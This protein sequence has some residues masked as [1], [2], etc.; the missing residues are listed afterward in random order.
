[1]S[2]RRLACALLALAS[3][4]AAWAEAGTEWPSWGNDPGG[5]RYADLRQISPENV[6][7]LEI[8][9]THRTGD[10]SDGTGFGAKSAFEAT[11][12][13]LEN[14]LYFCTPFNRVIA[15]D[16]ATGTERWS[17]DPKIDRTAR[18]ANQ[19]TC[20]GVAAWRDPA[21]DPPAACS[22]R[23]FT[24]TNDARLFALDARS[25]RLCPDFGVGGVVDLNPGVG[26]QEWRGEYQVT[27]PPAIANGIVAVGSAISDNMR[28]DAPSGVVRAFDARSGSLRWAW[29]AA[30]PGPL[31]AGR[32]A[33][34]GWALGSPNVWAP[35]SVDE[36]RDL[37]FAPTGN[38]APDYYGG[39]R[40]PLERYGSSV[41]ALRAASGQV[42]WHFQTV[43]HDLWDYDVA[44]QPTLSE[45]A[46]D[47]RRIPAVI[48]G[49]KMGMLFVLD[50]ET[51]EPLFP[52]EERPVP[53]SRV[54]GEVS[55]PTQP[56]PVKPP[57]LAAHALP[58]D[59]AWG[60]TPLDRAWCRQ[61]LAKLRYEGIYTPPDL[62]EGTLMYPG[63][64]G[65]INWGGVAVDPVRRIL[66]VNVNQVPF[67][68]SLMPAAQLDS[69][70][71]TGHG[72]H[73]AEYAPQR[74]TPY[75]MRRTLFVSPL[76]APCT[77]PPWGKLVAVDLDR[78]EIRWDVAFGTLRDIAPVPIPIELGT[79]NA[80]GPLVTSAGLVFIG[81]ALDDYLR[82]FDT[83]TG[84]ELWRGRLPAGGQ[85]TPMSYL[86]GGRQFVVI[87]A[88]GSGSA[89]TRPGDFVVAFALP[90]P[91]E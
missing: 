13:L 60:F 70:K 31:P 86:S 14:T 56:F 16:P 3:A 36:A 69:A 22:L 79:P 90:A 81:A 35:M 11:P 73:S 15:L 33:G 80:G 52:I 7:R 91:A 17:F 12:L 20:R 21:A 64:A 19:L 44:S 89:Q 59:G 37:I 58:G 5:A 78:G 32:A 66:I 40:R 28:T 1:L 30:P 62:G 82:A 29:D 48:Q 84:R 85:A 4:R 67:R 39:L 41:V 24:A 10:V 18:Y 87:A 6:A 27:S 74:G 42:L 61:Q 68:V 38:P 9:W 45:I 43:H 57:P 26:K 47:G 83:E 49:T 8:A 50:R 46:R 55:A 77:P 25:G 65:G 88:G 2:G 71:L 63:N 75:A 53:A 34:T 72:L 51:G 76:G 54:P 23:I